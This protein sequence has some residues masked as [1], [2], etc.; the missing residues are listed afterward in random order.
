MKDGRSSCVGCEHCVFNEIS[1]APRED[2]GIG[3]GWECTYTQSCRRILNEPSDDDISTYM[4]EW[5]P[6]KQEKE[7]ERKTEPKEYYGLPL[8]HEMLK[9]MAEVHSNKNHDY[10]GEEDPFQNLTA[11]ERISVRCPHCNKAHKL[12]AWIGVLIRLQDKLSRL[13]SM[14]G[15]DSKVVDESIDDTLLDSANYNL[16]ARILRR[17][18]EGIIEGKEKDTKCTSTC[19]PRARRYWRCGVDSEGRS[20]LDPTYNH[21]KDCECGECRQLRQAGVI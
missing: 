3:P 10:S 9:E 4:P 2:G 8:F 19:R 11:C 21:D 15:L 17:R 14:A 12:D 5:C 1:V 13:E 16:I 6:L 20:P 18:A 7:D